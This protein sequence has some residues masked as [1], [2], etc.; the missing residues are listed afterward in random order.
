M[1][2]SVQIVDWTSRNIFKIFKKKVNSLRIVFK[3]QSKINPNRL[4]IE[5]KHSERLIRNIG[6]TFCLAILTDDILYCQSPT[7][8]K[9]ISNYDHNYLFLGFLTSNEMEINWLSKFYIILNNII[10]NRILINYQTLSLNKIKLM[11]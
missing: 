3:V 4:F 11:Q 8:E 2:E 6:W 7:V 10:H 1:I 9:F 5:N